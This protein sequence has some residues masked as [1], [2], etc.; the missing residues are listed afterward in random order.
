MTA[1]KCLRVSGKH[2]DLENV[3]RTARHH[4]FFEMLGNFSFG[5]Y[6]KTDAIRLAWSFL[7]VEMGI[8]A[9]R[10]WVTVFEDDD[11]AARL[12]QDVAGV[13][14]DRIQRLGEK[15]NFWS[16]GD[17]GPCGPCSEIFYDHGPSHGPGGGPETESD[18][19]VEIWNLV[20]MQFDRDAEGTLTPLPKPSIDTGMGL[21]RLAAVKQGVYSNY[22]TDTFQAIIQRAAD[23]AKVRYGDDNEVDVA[24]RVIADHSRATAF[25]MADGVMPSNTERGYV[26]RRIMR[27]AIRFGVKIGLEASFMHHTV[28]SVIEQMAAAYPELSTRQSFILDVTQ[29]EEERFRRTLTKGLALLNET[30]AALPQDRRIIDGIVA[31]RLYETFGFPIDLTELIAAEQGVTV[32]MAGFNVEMER[33]KQ[34]NRD[35]HRGTGGKA[36]T[37]DLYTLA[38]QHSTRFL[39]YT[40]DHFAGAE[41]LA[42]ID[43]DGGQVDTLTGRGQVIV[44]AS[45]FYA[46]SGGQVGDT[47]TIRSGSGAAG[48]VTDTQKPT[49][50][51]F[52]H[53]VTIDEGSLSVGDTV[54]LTVDAVRRD[55]T[56]RN[57]TAT[58]LLHAAL[59]T[60]LGDHVMQK[61]S[62]VDAE[63]L[64]FDF[65]HPKAMTTEE[66]HQVED[67]VYTQILR[68]SALSSEVMGIASAKEQGAMALF[69]EKYGDE[70][71]VITVPGFSVELCGG[72]HAAATGDIGLFRVTSE[73]GIAAGVRRIEATTGV[74]ALRYI[75][76]RDVAVSEAASALKTTPADL[77]ENIGKLLESRRQLERELEAAR[78]QLALEQARVLRD[79]AT[80]V[81]GIKVISARLDTDAATLRIA[82]EWI[83]DSLDGPSVVVLGAADGDSVKLVTVVS[84]DIAG[85]RVHAG[86][87]IRTV[88]KL[89]GGGGGGRPDMA[90]AG[91]RDAS[92]L[93]DALEQVFALVGA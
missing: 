40:H 65:A 77:A 10:L 82:A 53:S 1:Q 42:L 90:Q 4:T 5:D 49:G 91:G 68:N 45:P 58:H 83:R 69:G 71:R 87:V 43:A 60:V 2:N 75:R 79:G 70:V 47:G 13:A 78:R 93:P 16:M 37:A 48:V 30:I 27:R 52:L 81:D 72:I 61:G 51:L 32:D 19:Y 55:H 64:R 8:P 89:V 7:T 15:D 62:L 59:R 74:G 57:H 46:E 6:F 88:A 36:I 25:L 38:E 41:I 21:E 17:T 44:D 39:G 31:T 76:A 35:R 12:W 26:L 24:L 63:R 86:K 14:P 92:K 22:D 9:D 3:G 85:K 67:M 50:D 18:R 28:A 33:L 66:L 34:I 20:F 80:V 56:R 29:G 54:E 11:E 84:Q 73:S 23:V